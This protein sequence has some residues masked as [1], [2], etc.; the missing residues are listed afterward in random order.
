VVIPG[1]VIESW[2]MNAGSFDARPD[3]VNEWTITLPEPLINFVQAK[4]RTEKTGGA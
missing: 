1:L 3:R 4:L 2:R